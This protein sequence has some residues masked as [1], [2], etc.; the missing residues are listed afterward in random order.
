MLKKVLDRT[1]RKLESAKKKSFLNNYGL[2]GAMAVARYG[3]PRAT[4]DF[5]FF[6]SLEKDNVALLA[7][8]LKAEYKIGSVSDPLN[9]VITFNVKDEVGELPVQLIVFPKK[10]DELLCEHVEVLDF[11]GIQLNILNWKALI[12]LKLYAGSSRDLEDVKGILDVQKL[13]KADM[14]WLKAKASAFRV[15]KKLERVM[16]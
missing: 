8:D 9:A 1:V 5:D 14:E 6:V 10:W 13:T 16:G 2:I 11:E 4:A 15:S 7:G 3:V 12:L